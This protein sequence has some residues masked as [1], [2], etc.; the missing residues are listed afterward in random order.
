MECDHCGEVCLSDKVEVEKYNFCCIGCKTVFE[1]LNSHNLDQYYELERRPGSTIK[2][3]ED[4]VFLDN[5]EIIEKFTSFKNEEMSKVSFSIPQIHCSS[6]I[7]LLENLGRFDDEIFYSIVNFNK[8]TVTISYGSNLSLREL[9]EIL[10]SI[11]YAP[12]LNTSLDKDVKKT[13]KSLFFKI[14]VAGFCFGNIMLLSFP[15]YL[16]L[17][18]SFKEFQLFFGVLA[19]LLSIPAVFYSGSEYI[20]NAYRG[21]RQRFVN[22]DIPIAL[23]IVTLFV[24]SVYEILTATGAGYL[25]SLTGL[26]FFLLLGKW[27]QKKTYSTLSFDRNYKSYFPIAVNKIEDNSSL[28]TQ[29]ENLE[30]DDIIEF[31]NN[32]LVPADGVLTSESTKIDYS[33]V[34]GESELVSKN[35]NDTIYAGGRIVGGKVRMKLS[36]SVDNSYLTQLWNQDAFNDKEELSAISNS[37]SKY[38]TMVVLLITLITAVYWMLTDSSM[39]WNSVSSVLI[40][41]CPCALALSVPFTFG[42]VIRI[43]G[44][45]GFYLKNVN[46]I[47]RLSKIGTVVF[48]KTGTITEK[49]NN[50]VQY[51]GEDLTKTERRAIFSL[52]SNSLHPQS[53]AIRN[54]FNELSADSVLNFQEISGNG[55]IGKVNDSLV[56]IGSSLFLGIIPISK[57]EFSSEV[58]VMIDGEYKGYY[59]IDQKYRGGLVELI[60][61]L[62]SNFDI[63]LLTGDND[64]QK[65]RLE[66]QFGLKKMRFNQQ[67]INKLEYIKG[68]QEKKSHV[69]MI[70]DGL[71]DAGALK[72]S[73][74]GIAISDDIHQFSPAC[75]A[76]LEANRLKDLDKYITYSKKATSIVWMSFGLS[77]LY[78]IVG[79]SFAVTGQLTPIVAAILM[80]LSSI[81]AAVFTVFTSQVIAKRIFKTN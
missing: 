25:D 48:D 23:G 14:G 5:E 56:K 26:I 4:Y 55:I 3:I 42:S 29:I 30:P 6:C 41:A 74:V 65:R 66:E 32:E 43:M 46:V 31:R 37:V 79:I 40:V 33:F 80:P 49:G 54:Y 19:V 28:P 17:D 38:F 36:K 76:I 70:G 35:K 71:N 24:R 73:D 12:D 68:L 50:K 52:V 60:D 63:H 11:G 16:G 47:E 20:K 62:K 69:L 10:S 57:E 59:Q 34:T 13:N 77:F 2:Q 58:H 18:F 78:N 44:K 72:Q 51:I 67:P 22:M 53:V 81:T 8:R 27:F 64:G 21:I 7:W 1:L 75:D 9:V 61:S 15:E 39:I 45:K